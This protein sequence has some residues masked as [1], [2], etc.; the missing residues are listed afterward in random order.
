MSTVGQPSIRP[1]IGSETFAGP[2]S[3]SAAMPS[4]SWTATRRRPCYDADR[5]PLPP[6]TLADMA[7]SSLAVDPTVPR[8]PL[9][10]A[11]YDLLIENGAFGREPVE[12]LEGELVRMAPQGPL[13]A[14]ATD[15]L[16]RRLDRL[17]MSA[18]GDL[19]V[20]R[21]EKP[22]AASDLSEPEP[23]IAVIDAADAAWDVPG[24][25][26]V[27]H[28][29]AEVAETSRRVDLAHKPRIYA[30][31]GVPEYW[32]VDLPRRCIVVHE[33]PR[34][35]GPTSGDAGYDRVTTHP[36]GAP[37]TVLGVTL[38]VTDVLPPLTS[39]TG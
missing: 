9:T 22:F 32:V 15:L 8:S 7:V 2:G 19:Y 36:C 26:A 39:G 16:A 34:S 21:Q 38:R 17:L 5:V 18:H 31:S 14:R 23:D 37:L 1:T 6:R 33:Q 24:H 10:R 30:G 25:P 20:V 29:I 3:I 35:P 28:L 12:L 27:A 13:H 11:M 4:V